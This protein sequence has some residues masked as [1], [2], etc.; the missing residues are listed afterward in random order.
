MASEGGGAAIGEL[1]LVEVRREAVE[2]VNQ[3]QTF[4][5]VDFDVRG[6]GLPVRGDDY[7]GLWF[8]GLGDF[9]ADGLEARVDWVGG[10]FENVGA[11]G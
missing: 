1:R 2:V 7:D 5:G 11:E 4:S 9:A 6:A 8:E 10:V 3:R